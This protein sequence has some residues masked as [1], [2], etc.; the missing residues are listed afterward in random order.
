MYGTKRVDLGKRG[1]FDVK[2]GAL[3]SMLHIPQDETIPQ[4]RLESAMHSN[5]PLER[6]RA[7]SAEGFRHMK[8]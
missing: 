5:D 2:K 6:K 1:S 8:H 3:H 4:T 7:R